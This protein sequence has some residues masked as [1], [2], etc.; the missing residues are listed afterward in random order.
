MLQ[1]TKLPTMTELTHIVQAQF[2]LQPL[3]LPDD[4]LLTRLLSYIRFSTNHSQWH[5]ISKPPLW[6][7]CT[8]HIDTLY[9]RQ[10][11][12]IHLKFLQNNLEQRRTVRNS[13]LLLLCRPTIPLDPHTIYYLDMH[14]RLQIPRTIVNPLSFLLNK[15]PTR[16]PHSSQTSS[17][18]NIRWSIIYVIL[19]EHDYLYHEKELPP[20]SNPRQRL[21]KLL[22]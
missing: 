19:R 2:L 1:P 14:H 9:K 13:N 10:L 3:S 6:K 16:K 17:L 8:Q 15:L 21:L 20:P 22:N 12:T 11:K 7:R 18:W 5:T 4:A